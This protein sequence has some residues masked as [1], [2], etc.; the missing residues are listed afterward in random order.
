MDDCRTMAPC[1][2]AS[3]PDDLPLIRRVAT[4]DQQA[5]EQLYQRYAP[6]LMRYLRRLLWH[7]DLAEEVLDEVWLIV[8][9]RAAH[10]DQRAQ[11][12]TWIFGIAHYRVLKAWRRTTRQVSSLPESL[13]DEPEQEIPEATLLHQEDLC[14]VRRALATLPP[15]QRAVV[16]L[17]YDQGY[18][19]QEI[20]TITGWPLNTVKTRLLRARRRLADVLA[21]TGLAPQ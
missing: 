10:F 19:Y 18:S 7:Q 17:T 12:S 20:A 11:L 14:R 1:V 13:R 3:A 16:E 4:G 2:P 15:E 6:R 5:F 9:Q 21:Q 8:W